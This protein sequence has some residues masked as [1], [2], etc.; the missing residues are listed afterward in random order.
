MTSTSIVLRAQ[1]SIIQTNPSAVRF[2]KPMAF[3]PLA[4][5]KDVAAFVI[6]EE[7]GVGSLSA[8][9]SWLKLVTNAYQVGLFWYYFSSQRDTDLAL[10]ARV[11]DSVNIPLRQ[12]LQFLKV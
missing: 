1:Q 4:G 8:V 9:S 7:G 10:P 3:E 2:W 11:Y 12:P 5:T 6:F